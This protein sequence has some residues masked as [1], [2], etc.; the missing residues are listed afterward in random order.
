MI[1]P[2]TLVSER[3]WSDGRLFFLAGPVQGGGGWQ[4]RCCLIMQ[5]EIGDGVVAVPCRWRSDHPL[6]ERRVSGRGDAFAR[7]L[8]WERYYLELAAQ[9]GGII[10]WLPCENIEN[11]RVDGQP[12]AMDT[13]GELGE[14]R[15]RMMREPALRVFIGAENGFPGLDQIARNFNEALGRPFPIYQSLEEL[16]QAVKGGRH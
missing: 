14:W 11:P 4:Y 10:F 16:V 3:E 7:Q 5:R 9:N 15:G 12:Y 13:R 8:S 2:K 1:L 6:F